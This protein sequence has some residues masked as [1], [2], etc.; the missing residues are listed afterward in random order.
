M[1]SRCPATLG[2]VCPGKEAQPRET[3]GDRWIVTFAV[4]VF[5]V[6]IVDGGHSV[7][8]KCKC[9]GRKAVGW[10]CLESAFLYSSEWGFANHFTSQ[11]VDAA[12]L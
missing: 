4:K 5:V 11:G 3:W 7:V 2:Y 1:R 12:R 9:E 6:L 8:R 10:K